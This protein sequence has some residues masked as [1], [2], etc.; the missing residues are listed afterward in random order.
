[1][2]SLGLSRPMFVWSSCSLLIR[3]T[4]VGIGAVW[5]LVGVAA[6][7]A[8]SQWLGLLLFSI[9]VGRYTPVGPVD[10]ARWTGPAAFAAASA[11]MAGI[12]A[13]PVW[14][15]DSAMTSLALGVPVFGVLYLSAL[16]ASTSGRRIIREVWQLA[17]EMIFRETAVREPPAPTTADR[18]VEGGG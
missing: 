16:G 4:A 10:V 1:M 8:G 7:I 5:G 12:L 18:P 14:G 3:L 9:F 15:T 13:R 11:I 6:A 2:I 17:R